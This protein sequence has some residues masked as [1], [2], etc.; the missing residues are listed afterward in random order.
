MFP[1]ME[2]LNHCNYAKVILLSEFILIFISGYTLKEINES[3]FQ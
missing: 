2:I 3:K 1:D